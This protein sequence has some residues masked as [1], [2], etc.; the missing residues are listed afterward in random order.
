VTLD[1][2]DWLGHDVETIAVEKAGV[3]RQGRATVFGSETMPVSI[4]AA[5][6][7][8]GAIL[9][10]AGKDYKIEPGEDG[11]WTFH[12]EHRVFE[13]LVR[14]GLTGEFQVNNAAAVLMLLASA[15][16]A[17]KLDAALINDVLPRVKIAGR[18]QTHVALDRHWLL[19]VAHNPA[20]AEMLA[21]TL[22]S[23][24]FA[25]RTIAI[26]GVLDDKDV[27]GVIGPLLPHVD[28]WVAIEAR[29]SRAIPANELA[30]QVANLAG[31]PCLVAHSTRDAIEFARRSAS[32]NDRI[33]VT[34]SFFTV[35]P[36]TECLG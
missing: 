36:V 9:Y 28:Q 12:S 29:S 33:L 17:T 31:T 15:G 32:E 30:R 11:R 7:Q 34:G 19:D 25:G 26:V 27:A 20:A 18:M 22:A 8:S 5:A 23:E 2:C 24:H 6:E 10:C 14:P 13:S 1:H 3:M 16:L 4:A 35:A 21:A